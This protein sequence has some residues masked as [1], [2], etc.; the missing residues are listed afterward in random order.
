MLR[1]VNLGDD[2]DTTGAVC[3]ELAGGCW[4]EAGIPKE[5]L[6]GQARRKIIETALQGLV[7]SSGTIEESKK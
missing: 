6:G 5:W 1:A 7:G 2:T 4:G 3:G